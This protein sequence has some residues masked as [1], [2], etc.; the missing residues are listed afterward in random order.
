MAMSDAQREQEINR[1]QEWLMMA[2]SGIYVGEMP[3]QKAAETA[4]E[5]GRID[6]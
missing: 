5:N 1:L 6:G 3:T 2:D 4:Y